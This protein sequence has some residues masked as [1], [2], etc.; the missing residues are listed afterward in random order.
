MGR[1][2]RMY[3]TLMEKAWSMKIAAKCP[4][5]L[6]NEFYLT[7]TNL[8]EK[9]KTLIDENVAPDKLWYNKKPDYSYLREIGC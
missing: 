1:V 4:P 3:R 8:H 5:N 9:T 6:W 7:A 2:E